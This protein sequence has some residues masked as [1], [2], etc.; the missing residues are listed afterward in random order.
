MARILVVDDDPDILRLMQFTL[1]NAKHTVVVAPDGPTALNAINKKKPDL[2]IVDIMMPQM[3]GYQFTQRVRAMPGLKN[4]PILVYS[5]RFQ[6]IDQETAINAGATDYMPKTVAPADIVLKVNELLADDAP[7]ASAPGGITIGFFSLRGGVGVSTLA[8]NIAAVIGLSKK[9]PTV[10]ADLHPLAGHAGLMLGLRPKK[11]LADLQHTSD[12]LTEEVLNAVL[13][14][15]PKTGV[16]LLASPLI[17]RAAPVVHNL[18]AIA[19][20]IKSAYP[21]AIFDLPSVFSKDV[22][23]IMP[24]L[25][26]LVLVTAPDLP[27]LQSAAVARKT[28]AALDAPPKRVCLVFNGNTAT[29]TLKRASMEKT[30][31]TSL[32]AEIPFEPT[33]CKA[34]H[35]G[36]PLALSNPQA[37][38]TTAIAQLAAK[39][40]KE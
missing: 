19:K 1:S 40:L 18:E 32:F 37:P 35:S 13:A 31:R 7:A 39:L 11:S 3:T 38:F 28:I 16:R 15:H 2:I 23:A 6:P 14:P 9:A 12:S 27:S 8:V 36:Q 17:R 21:F 24:L 5:A 22:L 4:L 30:L 29:P 33:L 34:I 26:K 10:L 25:D 20:Q